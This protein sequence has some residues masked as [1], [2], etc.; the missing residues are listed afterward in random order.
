MRTPQPTTALRFVGAAGL[1]CDG[2]DLVEPPPTGHAL[3][4]GVVL[5]GSCTADGTPR[6]NGLL[7]AKGGLW[8]RGSTAVRLTVGAPPEPEWCVWPVG[9]FV[10]GPATVSLLVETKRERATVT[11]NAPATTNS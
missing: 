2:S 8:V 1:R 11:V 9:F 10:S 6:E 3:T 7:F 4:D 5:A